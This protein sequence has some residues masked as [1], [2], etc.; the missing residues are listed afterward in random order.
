VIVFPAITH[1]HKNHGFLLQ[2]LAHAGGAWSDPALRVVFAGS[3]GHAEGDVRAMVASL[4]LGERVV[5]PGRVP[6]ADRNGLLAIADAMVFPSEYEGFGAP[7]IEAMRMGAPVIA[8]DRAS[9]PEVVGGAGLVLPLRADAW[10]GALDE[11]RGRRDALLAAG[12]ARA[13]TYTAELSARDLVD[14]YGRVLA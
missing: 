1:P 13:A 7:L 3:A 5:M 9:I 14:A 8:S 4:G 12:T 2:L 10:A 11:V 6:A